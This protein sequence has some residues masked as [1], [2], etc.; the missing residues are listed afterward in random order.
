MIYGPQPRTKHVAG[1]L[2]TVEVGKVGMDLDYLVADRLGRCP[3]TN[4][5]NR[6]TPM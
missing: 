1:Y 2:P 3:Y 6:L 5:P 4:R